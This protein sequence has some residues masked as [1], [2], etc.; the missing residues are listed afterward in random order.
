M[1]NKRLNAIITIG[2]TVTGSLT[3]ALGSTRTKLRAIGDAVRDL[4][5]D[6][7]ALGKSIRDAMQNGRPVGELSQKYRELEDR[8]KSARREQERM[9][10]AVRGM[11]AGKAMMGRGA[12]MVGGAAAAAAVGIVPVVAAASYEKAMLGVAKQVDGARDANGKLTAVYWDMFKA[13]QML[14]REVPVPTNELAKMAEQ[15]AR[16]GVPKENLIEFVRT[17]AKMGTAMDLPREEL[18]DDM[19]KI[20][21]L[22]KLPIPEIEKLGDAINYLDDNAVSKGGDI[23]DFLRRTGGVAGAVKVTGKEMA[24]LG[25]TL[26]SLGERSE[27]ASTASNAFIQKLA[28][29]EKGPKKFQRAMEELGL[30]SEQVQ[31][32]MQK[33][34]QGTMLKVLDA[35]NK[36]PK[37]KQLGVLVD[38]VGLEHSDTIAK[39]SNGVAEYRKQIDMV[40]SQKV[41]GSMSREFTAQLA[42]TNAQWEITK[43]RVFEVGVNIGTV[44][45]PPVNAMLD[46][47]GKATGVIADFVQEHPRL[48]KNIAFVA[49]A[50]IGSLAVWGAL[51]FA[52]GA[53]QTAFWGLAAAIIANPIGLTIAVIAA[54]AALIYANWDVIAP[55]FEGLWAKVKEYTGIAW[56]FV[57]TVFLNTNPLGMVIKNWEPLKAFFSSLFDEIKATVRSAIDWVLDKIAA[58]GNAWTKTKQFFG[59][60]DEEAGAVSG[61]PTPRVPT[62]PPPPMATGRGAG[63]AFTDNSQN[64]FTIVQKPNQDPRELANVVADEQERRRRQRSGGMLFDPA[65]GY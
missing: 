44:L 48:V 28:A 14:G 2:G 18:A 52:V 29:A 10:N 60:G 40:N 6:E 43:N 4:E 57:K 33:D 42:S 30:S 15:G 17:T 61:K 12:A 56:E 38:L 34:A 35:V 46:V 21:N 5:R 24:A 65:R 16:M 20:A 26:L 50:V 3:S 55:F 31:K 41:E 45:L 25:S 63:G 9:S 37:D 51:T 11:D 54:G 13:I 49:G 27:T 64:S 32:D 19:G 8:I 36:L 1:A 59:F 47:F 23:I 53:V 22:F 39:L 62:S 58:V 7:K